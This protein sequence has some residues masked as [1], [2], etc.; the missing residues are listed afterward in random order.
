MKRVLENIFRRKDVCDFIEEI[1]SDDYKFEKKDYT[2]N[3]CNTTSVE[4]VLFTFFDALFK[5]QIILDTDVFLDEYIV[6]VKKLLKKLDNYYDINLG[7]AKII[8]KLCAL[9]LDISDR[10]E[11]DSKRK[12]LEYVYDRYIVHGYLFHGFSGAYKEQIQKFGLIPE[13][14]QHSYSQF[15]EVD[16]IFNKHN[17]LDVMGKD[18]YGNY[19]TFTDDFMMGC[20]YGVYSPMYFSRLFSYKMGD[21]SHDL[22]AYFKNDYF[23]CFRNLNKLMKVAGL[24]D[25]EKKYITRVCCDEWKVLQRS[26]SNIH[27]LLVKREKLGCHQL[28][29][30]DDI[31]RSSSDL[32][33]GIL[34]IIGSKCNDIVTDSKLE[35]SDISFIEIPNYKVLFLLREK[36]AYEI[37]S[38]N[39]IIKDNN[40]RLSNAYGKVSALILLGSLLITL[41]V[42]LTIITISKGM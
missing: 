17:F 20:Y 35:S 10:N 22:D 33:E 28:K 11:N 29:D 24:N 32:G 25:Y 6:Q 9:K 34:R 5:Y 4:Q 30:I 23:S 19:V 38:K 2:I 42:I 7:I 3:N 39:R 13:A 40:E 21:E 8:G 27:I 41:G 1:L 15:I 31:L 26:S 37:V 18:F 12:I 16:K 36:Q 14:Y